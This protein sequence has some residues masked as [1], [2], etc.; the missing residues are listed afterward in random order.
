VPAPVV[1]GRRALAVPALVLAVGAGVLLGSMAGGE[2]RAR[3]VAA[4]PVAPA[5]PVDGAGAGVERL[6]REVGALEAAGGPT[7]AAKADLLRSDLVA[8]EQGATRP[9]AP[10][11]P[12]V[13]TAARIAAAR[14]TEAGRVDRAAFDDG[15]VECEPIPGGVLGSGELE[16]ARCSSTLQDDGS[17]LYVVERPDGSTSTVRFTTDHPGGTS[18]TVTSQ[19]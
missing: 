16:G 17:S 13:D 4:A 15:P 9:P 14:A 12:G 6:R 7:A 2:A 1:H 5:A 8:L 11:E 19:S 18:L 3:P 10:P